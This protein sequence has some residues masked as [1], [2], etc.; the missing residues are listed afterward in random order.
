MREAAGKRM[1]ADVTA[2]KVKKRPRRAREL[3]R[4]MPFRTEPWASNLRDPH[5]ARRKPRVKDVYP[6]HTSRRLQRR[7]GHSDGRNAD[8]KLAAGA[9]AV[10]SNPH[11]APVVFDDRFHEREPDAETALAAAPA[12]ADLNEALEDPV[13]HRAID[14]DALI[15]HADQREALVLEGGDVDASPLR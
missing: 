11:A 8:Y 13:L 10:A 5:A 2:R 6:P 1:S 7:R 15:A 9:Y 14:A 3:R 4:S 12:G